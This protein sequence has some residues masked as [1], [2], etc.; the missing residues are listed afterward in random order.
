MTAHTQQLSAPPES[1]EAVSVRVRGIYKSFGGVAAVQGVDI[2]IAG[3]TIHGF[4]G[5][6]GAG[7]STVGK[8]IAGVH[9]PDAGELYLADQ[10]VT[11]TS[12]RE[13][14][15]AGVTIVEQELSLV[16][17]RSVLDNVYLGQAANR[18]GVID[19]Q[20][21]LR[22]YQ[23][24]VDEVGFS[25][26]PDQLVGELRVA[27]QQKVE[28]M[29]AVARRSRVIVMDE[30]TASL[31]TAEAQ[32]LHNVL[33]DLRAK[34]VTVI[35][36]SHFLDE[37][38]DVCDT[39][40]VMRD[41]FLVGTYP[42]AEQSKSSLISLMVG[43][44]IESIFPDR[45][46]R[47][48]GATVLEV[49]G[50]RRPPVVNGVSFSVRAAE[51]VVLAGLVGSGRTE[52]AR[53]VFGADRRTSGRITIDGKDVDFRHTKQAIS[54]GVAMVPESRKIEGLLLGRS[55]EANLALAHPRVVSKFG[56][57]RRR[58]IDQL[59]E[60]LADITDL[61]PRAPKLDARS[62]SGGNQQK[63]L[64]GR[65]LAKT[66]R[67][68][69]LDEPTRGVDVGAKQ[70][71]YQLISDIADQGVAVLVISSE[72]EEVLGLADRV[73]V[74]RRGVV[75]AELTGA[76]IAEQQVISAAFGTKESADHDAN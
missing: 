67:L 52:F 62:F 63:I 47:V 5:E 16:P 12:P 69:I 73:L 11:F 18:F 51:I 20:A 34:G 14:L 65:W 36:I 37:V 50:V 43:R 1:S 57:L 46:D 6:N 53:L 49:D 7:K 30:P 61:R 35:L 58:S 55:A 19:R 29:R 8:V 13:A 45:S 44:D 17:H 71:L 2:A 70:K 68:L 59:V 41:G 38:L 42:T 9:T 10:E 23:R 28:I 76:D 31:T 33:K 60:R 21:T 40:T 4:V 64:Y 27:D 56:I 75:T 54:A 24:I 32:K 66:P 39:V 26:P 72:M 74:M 48:P 22:R 15:T 25:F 3:G